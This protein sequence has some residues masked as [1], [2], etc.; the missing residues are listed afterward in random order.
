MC[1]MVHWQR[2]CMVCK[3]EDFFSERVVH[4]PTIEDAGMANGMIDC[5]AKN[6][7][8]EANAAPYV[9]E[10]CLEKNEEANRE[11]WIL[12]DNLRMNG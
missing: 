10:D 5:V 1:L 12:M 9:C 7:P 6:K 4:C 2:V 3:M 11:T 8:V